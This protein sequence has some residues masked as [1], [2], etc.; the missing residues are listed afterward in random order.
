M[1]TRHALIPLSLAALFAMPAH[2]EY[3]REFTKDVLV[4]GRLQQAYG[5]SCMQPD[6]AW[7]IVQQPTI[8]A[9]PTVTY[10]Q[11]V[12]YVQPVTYYNSYSRPYYP[13]TSSFSF[14]YNS[15]DRW[16]RHRG[17]RNHGYGWG[18]RKHG[19]GHGHW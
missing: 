19:H 13:R 17:Y 12:S 3:C 16:D 10:V 9:A 2:A 7:Q 8:Q 5:T 18:H 11:P 4:G 14:I 1:K 6:G 15:G